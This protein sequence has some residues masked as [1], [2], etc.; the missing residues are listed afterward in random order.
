MGACGGKSRNPALK[1][2]NT[3][4]Q[5]ADPNFV[6]GHDIFINLKQGSISSYYKIEKQL[7][8]GAF[9]CVRLVTH[10]STGNKRAMKQIKKDKI[11][12]EDE[13][14]M[15]AE[16][17]IL[18]E[19]DHPNIVK[20][21]ELFQDSKYYYLITEYLE[22]GE[23]FDKIKQ[24]HNFSEKMAADFMKQILSAVMYCHNRKIVH[25]DLKPENILLDSKKQG[26][27]IKIIDFGTSRKMVG[28]QK[29]TKRLGTPY[30]IA[31]EVLKR[32]YNEKCDVWSCGVIL[33]ILLC[34]YPPFG[35]EEAEI[36]QRI[37]AGKYEF[38]PEDWGKVSEDAKNLIRKML[39]VDPNKRLSAKQAYDDP[40]IQKNAPNQAL[41][42]KAIKNLSSFQGKNKL[43]AAIMQFI[44]TQIMTNQEKEELQKAFRLIDKNGD[45]K[46][47]KDELFEVYSKQ[48]DEIKANQMVDEI[49]DK[50][51]SNKS[52]AIDYTEFISAASQE[53]KLLNKIKLEQTF[54]VF[55]INGDGQISREEL[56][57]IMGGAELDDKQWKEILQQCDKNNDGQISQAEFIDL[58]MTKYA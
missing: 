42:P 22:G 23:L 53:E 30:Y 40:W 17:N 37:E 2:E 36:L 31:P 26:T 33:Y 5:Q 4:G 41:D 20:L 55:D 39:E 13:E 21:H 38:D 10:K 49:F 54:K 44:A 46:I 8:E 6:V 35:G 47:G 50:V 52:G 1:A 24:L 27:N 58:L 34:G 48:Y 19:L 29:L 3:G 51:D 43:K 18:K 45:G 15:F 25:R 14:S 12:K 7:G 16:V 57:E 28:D 32:N 56:A 11:I 9:G